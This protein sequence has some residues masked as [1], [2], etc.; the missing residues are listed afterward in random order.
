MEK[1]TSGAGQTS[2]SHPAARLDPH[3]GVFY[4]LMSFK[5]REILLV[6]SAY[7]AYI[8][9]ED[10]SLAMRI[11]NEYRGLNLSRP[12]RIT[13]VSTVEQALALLKK[14]SFDLILTMPRL[15]GMDCAAFAGK[16]KKLYPEAVS[17]THLTL[18]TNREV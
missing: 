17:Y 4:E 8:M 9:E 7:D 18:P 3:F 13:R 6:S 11:I 2:D 14:N 5:V 10:G 16:V 15:G 1:T 12:P